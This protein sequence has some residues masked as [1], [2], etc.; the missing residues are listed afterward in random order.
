LFEA[1]NFKQ[2][3]FDSHME[4]EA[5]AALFARG[6]NIGITLAESPLMRNTFLQLKPKNVHDIAKCLAIIRPAAAKARSSPAKD[7][8]IYDDDA[9][10][11][12]QKFV[13]CDAEE[14]DNLRRIIT[15]TTKKE[16][17]RILAAEGIELPEG[18]QK[19]LDDIQKYS[20]CKSHAYSYAQLVW[21]LGYMKAHHPQQFWSAALRHCQ[22]SYRKWVH[23]YEA[24]L[25][26]VEIDSSISP[27]ASIYANHR[28][29]RLKAGASTKERVKALG[30]WGDDDDCEFYPECSLITQATGEIHIRGLIA[31]SRALSY[32]KTKTVQL[33]I[34]Y[35]PQAYVSLKLSGKFI[36]VQ[37]SIGIT[38]RAAKRADDGSLEADKCEFW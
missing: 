7:A 1:Q 6:D 19:V 18:S 12:I 31:N 32:G 15:K 11:L 17:R 33:L 2:I 37:S 20:F 3:D 29:Q 16:L 23:I 10:T 35:A 5:T 25:A 8:I 36:P 27:G 28:R 30:V 4:D 14:A 22:S 34:G 26:G 21:Q 24:K 13:G 38:C 9:I